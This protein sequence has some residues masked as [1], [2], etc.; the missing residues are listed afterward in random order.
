MLGAIIGDVI[1]S[2]YE[3][4]SDKSKDFRLFDGACRAT[5]DSIMTIAVGCACV[6]SDIDDEEAFKSCLVE[7]MRELGREY[8]DA[9]YGRM[10]YEWLMSDTKGDYGSRSNGSAMRVSPVAW[11][12]DSIEQAETLAKWSAEVTHSH[13]EGIRGA[14]AVAAAVYMARNGSGKDEIREYIEDKYYNLGF[15]VDEIR[16]G[17][18]FDVSCEGSVP[19][20]IVCF[21][22]SEDFEDAVRNAVSLGGDADTQGCIAGA[23]AEA[24]YGIPEDIQEEVFDYLDETLQDY[25]WGY[26][27]ELYNR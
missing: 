12:A 2:P 18:R 16:P 15:T 4:Y 22:E 25:Y 13:P 27:Q 11:A 24:F 9:G 1:G 19:Q 26:S 20:A 14:Q 8:P 10:F 17:Y 7:R 5:D 21:L 6:D 3:T 23:I